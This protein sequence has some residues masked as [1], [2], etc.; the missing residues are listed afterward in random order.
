[1]PNGTVVLFQSC[2]EYVK[3]SA[4]VEHDDVQKAVHGGY[5]CSTEQRCERLRDIEYLV[6]RRLFVAE[7][8]EPFVRQDS[9]RRVP[10]TVV[11]VHIHN[12][13]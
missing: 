2:G 13:R 9:S 6:R 5:C 1:M 12:R 3:L 10:E 7:R 8:I 11:T 4:H